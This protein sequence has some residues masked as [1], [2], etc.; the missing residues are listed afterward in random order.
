MC[1]WGCTLKTASTWC[2]HQPTGP[3]PIAYT[4]GHWKH[5]L[6]VSLLS[7]RLASLFDCIVVERC[8]DT[9]A[10]VRTDIVQ[11]VGSWTANCPGHFMEDK[12]LRY[13]AWGMADKVCYHCDHLSVCIA[14]LERCWH[15]ADP[16]LCCIAFLWDSTWLWLLHKLLHRLL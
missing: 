3:P 7:K 2:A 6:Q 16:A 14:A 12:Y 8:R 11:A 1:L 4:G 13:L 15:G 10:A 5:A 9:Q